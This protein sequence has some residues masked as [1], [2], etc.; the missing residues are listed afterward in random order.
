MKN[1]FVLFL[2]FTL[3]AYAQKNI[4]AF[5]L[6]GV[7]D[8]NLNLFVPYVFSWESIPSIDNRY[9]AVFSAGYERKSKT[10]FSF[11]MAVRD[12]FRKIDYVYIQA[13]TGGFIQNTLE[14][15]IGVR[16]TKTLNAQYK[17]RLELSP[18]INY[19]LTRDD[20]TI[21]SGDPTSESTLQFVKSTSPGFFA[22]TG[23]GLESKITEKSSLVIFL[24]WQYQAT[25]LFKFKTNSFLTE[26][27]SNPVHLNY[28]SFGL[29]YRFFGS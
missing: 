26:R 28:F 8:K 23:I 25:S 24:S 12:V 5:S 18:G 19:V 21:Q 15:P 1:T 29:G 16:Y 14:V 7:K 2:F 11:V 20:K 27:Y 6:A 10:A 9:A 13:V 17:F 4:F 22:Q 3:T